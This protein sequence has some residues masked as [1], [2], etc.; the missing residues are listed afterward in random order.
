MPCQPHPFNKHT[1]IILSIGFLLA[2]GVY[3]LLWLQALIYPIV[4]TTHE[5]GHAL[6]GWLFGYPS[7][8]LFDFSQR[9]GMTLH[10]NQNLAVLL[11]IYL[12]LASLLFRYRHNSLTLSVLIVSIFTYS[13]IAFTRLSNALIVFMGHGA[14]L[15]LASILL[16]F[17]FANHTLLLRLLYAMLGFF[18]VLYDLS[19]AYKLKYDFSYQLIYA[20]HSSG[21]R[22]G[23]FSRLA[24]YFNGKVS[25]VANLFFWCCFL[26]PLGS[27]ILF[28]YQNCVRDWLS[29][30]KQ[31][32]SS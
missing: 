12:T 1:W 24:L 2:L 25:T 3:H 31:L 17:A 14:E 29:K 27:F 7:L 8:P 4:T 26:P 21:N 18:I 32:E 11:S 13:I 28:R 30:L 20:Y 10:A 16:Y 15:I 5:L 23:D 22:L 9:E 19:F 6:V